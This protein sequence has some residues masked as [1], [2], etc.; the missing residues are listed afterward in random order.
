MAKVRWF[1]LYRREGRD[2]VY[3]YEPLKKYEL[4]ARKRKGWKVI[5]SR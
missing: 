4:N 3:L 5:E 2:R 1:L